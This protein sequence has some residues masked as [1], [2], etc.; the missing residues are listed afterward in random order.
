M[1][2]ILAILFALA[3]AVSMTACGGAEETTL[4]GMVVSVDG[5]VVTLMEMDGTMGGG[6]FDWSNMPTMPA[7][8]E[9]FGNFNPED[10]GGAMPDGENFPQWGGEMPER[11]EGAEL[12]E[13]AEMPEMGQMPNFGGGMDFN[14]EEYASEVQTR[15]VDVADAHISVEIDGGKASGTLEDLTPG[16]F[17]TVTL[18]SR[19]AATYVLISAQS[20][21]G[22]RQMN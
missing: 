11:P 2:R 10:F 13:G 22:G 8:M 15:E 21:F 1:K 16:A 7:G 19:G 20:G 3:L 5:T 9:G 4:T 12:P 18:N 6:E 17:V 14:F